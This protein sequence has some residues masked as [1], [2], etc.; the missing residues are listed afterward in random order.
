MRMCRLT[1]KS[2]IHLPKEM[3]K[4][5]MFCERSSSE[6][7]V[8]SL[9]ISVCSFRQ[10]SQGRLIQVFQYSG[11]DIHTLEPD[12]DDRIVE[13]ISLIRAETAK[14]K[15]VDMALLAQYFT[16]DVLT[17]IAFGAPF[18]YLVRNEDVYH[19][20]KE[21][22]SFLSILELA[23]NFTFINNILSSRLMRPFAPKTTDKSGMGAM[24]GVAKDIVA[25]RYAPDAKVYPDMMGSFLK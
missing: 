14:G 15:L 2:K 12:I 8:C 20:I 17:R 13:L 16:L 6:G 24:L 22:T 25:K 9:I 23:S 18:D 1:Q 19:Y 5:I 10:T 4:P 11:K 3:R 21:T 7:Y